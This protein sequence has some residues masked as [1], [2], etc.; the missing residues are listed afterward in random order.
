MA[1]EQTVSR[2]PH[3]HGTGVDPAAKPWLAQ[4]EPGVPASIDYPDVAL[5]QLLAD[6]VARH[7]DRPA[8]VY[9]GRTMTYRELDRA[10]AQFANRLRQF[11]LRQGDRV[12]VILPNCPQFLICHFGILRAGGVVAAISPL[13]VQREVEELARDAGAKIV[14][15]LDRFYEKVADLHR[16]GEVER[17]IVAS[18]DEYLP[19]HLRL[20]YPLGA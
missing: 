5:P 2:A 15:V 18:P 13:L 19:L 7:A 11:G 9:F 3:T 4:Y 14:V 8:L 6:A 1:S 10:A 20:L 17:V 16:R 12:L